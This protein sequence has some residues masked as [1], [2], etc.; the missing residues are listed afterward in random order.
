MKL[1]DIRSIDVSSKRIFLRL[2]LDVYLE[3][4]QILDDARLHAA[5][6]TVEYLLS[7]GAKIIIAGHLGRPEGKDPNLS[8][9]PVAQWF[10]RKLNISISEEKIGELEGWN[11]GDSVSILENL[12]FYPGEESNDAEFTKEL[13]SLADIYVNDAF[14]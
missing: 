9:L 14:G 10:E 6:P 7:K 8:L 2:D 12:R 3:N 13:S 11:L 4:G 1:P 5:F